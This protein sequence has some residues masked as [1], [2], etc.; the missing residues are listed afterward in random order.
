MSRLTNALGETNKIYGLVDKASAM[1]KLF[2]N[3]DGFFAY[4]QAI[5]KLGEL[6]DI[7]CPADAPEI[8]LDEL[9]E[10]CAAK[11]EQRFIAPYP[12]GTKLYYVET[13]G[14]LK[15]QVQ[16]IIAHGYSESKWQGKINAGKDNRFIICHNS[17]NEP[18]AYQL[19]NVYPSRSAAEAALAK[20][21]EKQ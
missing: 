2:T 6:E 12:T 10:M 4:H 5:H 21:G 9:R 1:P 19:C 13:D 18:H 17:Y 15:G 7:L 20:E 3:Y 11:R 16:E 8:T 14:I